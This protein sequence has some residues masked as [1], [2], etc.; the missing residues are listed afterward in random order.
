MTTSMG[1]VGVHIA[2]QMWKCDFQTGNIKWKFVG[3][4]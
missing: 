4:P 2:E 3:C 1:W